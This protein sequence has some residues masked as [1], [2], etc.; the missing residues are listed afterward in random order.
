MSKLNNLCFRQQHAIK[1]VRQQPVLFQVL[2]LLLLAT[3][4]KADQ[5][6]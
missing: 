3:T 2:L 6:I 1:I 4:L 5:Q